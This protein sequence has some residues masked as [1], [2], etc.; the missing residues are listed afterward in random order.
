[1]RTT[2]ALAVTAAAGAFIG[3][4][5]PAAIAWDA[6]TIS[7]SP[8]TARRGQTVTVTVNASECKGGGHVS[9]SAFHQARLVPRG[10]TATARVR[11]N[12]NATIGSHEVTATCAG[13]SVTK[14]N[15]LTVIH[16][17][18]MGGLG[19]SSNTGAT[20]TDMAIGGT[21]VA[22]AV[23]GGGVFW[24]RRRNESRA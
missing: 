12:N 18:T 20:A 16:G 23:V 7:V 3:L 17:G 19:G 4:A 14:P 11:I 24:L 13:H 9:S 1:M 15:A 22:A 2:R 8:S 21:L 10:H 6:S 5:A